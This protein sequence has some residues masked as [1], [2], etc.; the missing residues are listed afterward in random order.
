MSWPLLS[1]PDAKKKHCLF[2]ELE[3]FVTPGAP[4]QRPLFQIICE[5]K[6]ACIYYDRVNLCTDLFHSSPELLQVLFAVAPLVRAGNIWPL[7]APGES[8]AGFIERKLRAYAAKSYSSQAQ[9]H[10]LHHHW[11]QII[12]ASSPGSRA[13]RTLQ[14]QETLQAIEAECLLAPAR[15]RDLLLLRLAHYRRINSFDRP[16]FIALIH[17]MGRSL[18]QP[19]SQLATRCAAHYARGATLHQTGTHAVYPGHVA[20]RYAEHCATFSALLSA[21]AHNSLLQHALARNDCAEHALL[22]LPIEALAEQLNSAQFK[23]F[24]HHYNGPLTTATA[25]R[26]V[27]PPPL[28]PLA[29]RIAS[30]EYIAATTSRCPAPSTHHEAVEIDCERP[31]LYLAAS[32]Q[33]HPI[34]MQQQLLLNM[35]INFPQG[36]PLQAVLSVLEVSRHL[37]QRQ[38]ANII[39]CS[40]ASYLGRTIAHKLRQQELRNCLDAKIIAPFNRRF[41]AQQLRLTVRDKH[42]I[43]L[44]AERPCTLYCRATTPPKVALQGQLRHCKTSARASAVLQN[45]HLFVT[46]IHSKL[47]AACLNFL[48]VRTVSRA[49]SEA[50]RVLQ[51]LHFKV[52]SPSRR[53][54]LLRQQV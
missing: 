42:L 36:A 48:D 20:Q 32:T 38:R 40:Q 45:L 33:E 46:P 52:C 30:L 13:Q 29:P 51:P 54:Y 9:L 47:L 5:L 23:H 53:Y 7:T 37:E 18:G 15:A 3:P 27:T 26:Q 2:V 19:M 21:N 25:A 22:A 43:L 28:A 6:R 1:Q 34:D 41:K 16:E 17:W 31:L 14:L 12:P 8:P 35:L 24:R 49:I 39:D 44:R 4:A 10:R 50:N 11:M